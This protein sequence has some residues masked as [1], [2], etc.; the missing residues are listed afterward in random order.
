MTTIRERTIGDYLEAL[1]SPNPAPGGG[2]VSGLVGALSAGLG[3]MVISLTIKNAPNAS[4][5]SDFARLQ[6]GI[7]TLLA[8]AELDESA[9]SGYLDASRLPKS[10]PEE[11][12][13]RR[14]AMLAAMV[15]AAEVPLQLAAAALDVLQGMRNVVEQGTIHAV[16]DAAIGVALAEA[17]VFAALSNV[18]VN[19]PLIKDDAI[20]ASVMQRADAIASATTTASAEL[21]AIV[22]VR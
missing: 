6:T 10:T 19:I 16:S 22:A 7:D 1:A 14:E 12:A 5:E 8:T 9:Y 15:H 3:Q 17:S 20:A 21:R 18:R 13:V 11:K 4:L 2:S